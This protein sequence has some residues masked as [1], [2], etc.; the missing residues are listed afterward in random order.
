MPIERL[1]KKLVAK[2]YVPP[3][4]IAYKVQDGDSW[5]NIALRYNLDPWDLIFLNFQT[6]SSPEVNWYLKRFVGCKKVTS[7]RKNWIFSSD[8]NPGI[9]YTPIRRIEMPP[10]VI[11]G[12]KTNKFKK[13]WAG[14]AKSHS[15]DLFVIGAHDVTGKIYNLGWE[16]DADIQNA[17]VNIN[18]YKF[19][20]GLGASIGAVFIIAHGYERA[21]EMNGVAG[22]WDFDISL[23]AKLADFLKGIKG[24]GKTID[25]IGKYKK[26]RYLTEGAIKN[27]GIVKPGIYTIPIPL[28]GVG[29][30]LWA[31]FKF[32]DVSVFNVGTGLP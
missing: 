2:E 7:D 28:A 21:S 17:V 4:S 8:A 31:G 14:L 25:T 5:Q 18:G 23:G 15:G 27:L 3:H 29:L 1:P 19:G 10:L 6:R 9:I 13:I 11:V 24:L 32:G 30:H 20:P 22:S 16:E 26:M 12:E